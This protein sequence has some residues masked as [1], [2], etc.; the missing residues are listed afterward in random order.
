MLLCIYGIIVAV[1]FGRIRK[2]AR[3]LAQDHPLAQV[4]YRS[5]PTPMLFVMLFVSL[6]LNT[7]VVVSLNVTPPNWTITSI[8]EMLLAGA[9]DAACFGIVAVFYF[10]AFDNVRPPQ[11]EHDEVLDQ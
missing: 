9:L 11:E 6:A 8:F 1:Q 7:F 4:L 5:S 10:T 2:T 3:L